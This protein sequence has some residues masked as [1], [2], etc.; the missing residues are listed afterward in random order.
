MILATWNDYQQVKFYTLVVIRCGAETQTVEG[1]TSLDER[2]LTL[3]FYP[4][5]LQVYMLTP[6][7]SIFHYFN[8]IYFSLE[9]II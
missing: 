9:L 8:C 6:F 5:I 2:N 7:K 1:S 4:N 3:T